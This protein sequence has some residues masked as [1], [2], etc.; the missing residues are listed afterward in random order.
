MRVRHGH[1]ELQ[2][3]AAGIVATEA[4]AGG[5]EAVGGLR[6][7]G[8]DPGV[9]VR[10]RRHLGDAVPVGNGQCVG[11]Q[12]RDHGLV[13]TVERM[14]ET[15]IGALGEHHLGVERGRIGRRRR[16]EILAEESERVAGLA[17]DVLQRGEGQIVGGRGMAVHAVLGEAHVRQAVG[18]IRRPVRRPAALRAEAVPAPEPAV[19]RGAVVADHDRRAVDR[20][21]LQRID[22]AAR[23]ARRRVHLLD[24]HRTVG[25]R[26][27]IGGPRAGGRP[28]GPEPGGHLRRVPDHDRR[29]GSEFA[30]LPGAAGEGRDEGPGVA[31]ILVVHPAGSGVA[32]AIVSEELVELRFVLGERQCRRLA[33]HGGEAAAERR[34]GRRH[35][36]RALGNTGRLGAAGDH[37]RD[38][39]RGGRTRRAPLHPTSVEHRE[40][41]LHA[42]NQCGNELR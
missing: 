3:G 23:R 6:R 35:R 9:V 42:G 2:P 1:V 8:A 21:E 33:D 14:P 37:R 40:A 29:M 31:H 28:V 11:A 26:R 18:R 10:L 22:V 5:Q 25:D 19:V 15:R 39:R 20:E 38:D 7:A 36:V 12:G 27:R 17:G 4:L 13:E 16:E 32:V 30:A 41:L 34:I 24:H